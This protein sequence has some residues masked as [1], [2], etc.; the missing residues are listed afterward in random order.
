MT[1]FL[2]NSKIFFLPKIYFLLFCDDADA[3]ETSLKLKRHH[4]CSKY[5]KKIKKRFLKLKIIIF[6]KYIFSSLNRSLVKTNDQVVETMH[7]EVSKRMADSKYYIKDYSNPN[8][9]L[10]LYK[11]IVHLNAYNL[12][13]SKPVIV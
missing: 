2:N 7:Q 12:G 4:F 1:E 11:C 3:L 8:H 10:Y 13:V 5:L 9:G 6:Y